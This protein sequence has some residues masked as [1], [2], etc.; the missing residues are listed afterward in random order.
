M[1][2]SYTPARVCELVNVLLSAQDEESR[3]AANRDL[4]LFQDTEEVSVL[5][6]CCQ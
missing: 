1:D 3:N 6:A 4:E 5:D 2:N